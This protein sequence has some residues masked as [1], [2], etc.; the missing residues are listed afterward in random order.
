MEGNL[1]YLLGRGGPE[2]MSVSQSPR[3]WCPTSWGK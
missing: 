2:D 3:G 1:T